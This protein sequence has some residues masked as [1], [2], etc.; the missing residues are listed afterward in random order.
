MSETAKVQEKPPAN[1]GVPDPPKKRPRFSADEQAKKKKKKRM[2]HYRFLR[3]SSREKIMFA[4][5]LS[6]MLDSGIPL[7]EA[8]EVMGGQVSSKSLRAML[9]VMMHDL[10]DGFTLS[11]SLSK[12]PRAFKPFSVN[13][14]RVGE[15]SGTLSN[16]L[17]YQSVQLEKANELRGKIRGALF[18]PFIILIGAVGIGSYLSFYLLPRLIPLFKSLDVPLPL[19]TRLLLATSEFLVQNW[20]WVLVG[21]AVF[22]ATASILYRIRPVRYLVH[23]AILRIPV[24]GRLSRAIQVAFFTRILGTLL[25]SGVQIVEAISVTADSAS[26]LVYRREL[27]K[28]AKNVERGEAITDEL[29]K[30]AHL[31]PRIATGMVKVGDRT[32]KL[33]ESLMNAAEF[34][35][36]EVDDLTK[37][38]ST[39]IEP[40]TLILVGA[41][42]GFIALSIVTPIYQLTEGVSR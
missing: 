34:S 24:L 35:E 30:N 16:A 17:R 19:T 5:H 1:S 23:R 13:I 32:G 36:R 27:R 11:S 40:F 9:R 3:L 22:F 37:N 14:V 6:I 21:M 42:V 39:L 38:L 28:L 31:F 29:V 12:F 7:R 18:Y 25:S 2:R 8:L 10:T 41:L 26:N 33:S 4:K 20:I 15:A